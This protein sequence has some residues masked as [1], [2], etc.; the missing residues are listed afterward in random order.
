MRIEAQTVELSTGMNSRYRIAIGDVTYDVEVGDVSSSPVQVT[1][2]GVDFEVEIP[3][4]V[5][6]PSAQLSQAMS[7]RRPVSRQ[8][9]AQRARPAAGAT[10][11]NQNVVRAPMPGRIVRVN[12]AVGD[13]VQRGQAL[14]VLESMKMENTIAAPRDGIVSQV[15]VATEDSV[16]H[17]QS[18]V[19]LE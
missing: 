1:V 15:Y 19:E 6:S 5:P 2:D 8:R 7:E 13:S 11:N 4:S 17:G 12:V 18:L 16:Q 3:N 10:S 14:V 9:P